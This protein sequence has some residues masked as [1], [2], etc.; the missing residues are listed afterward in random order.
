M[1]GAVGYY[2]LRRPRRAALEPGAALRVAAPRSARLSPACAL[3]AAAEECY[4]PGMNLGLPELLV[5]LAIIIL[6]FGANRL[7]ELGRGIG[8]G[9]QELQGSHDQRTT[10]RHDTLE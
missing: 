1:I 6:I 2:H 3:T 10:R 9:N 4:N 5:I 7:P 8:K